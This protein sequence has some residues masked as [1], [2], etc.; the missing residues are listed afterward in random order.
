MVF[1]FTKLSQSSLLECR[2]AQ[3]L[4][5][6]FFETGIPWWDFGSFFVFKI[7]KIKEVFYGIFFRSIR[8]YFYDSTLYI[9][10][11]WWPAYH[12]ICSMLFDKF[13]NM[14]AAP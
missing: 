2:P 9:F 1:G 12:L 7:N 4:P 8:L 6:Q 10:M 14:S 5:Y 3:G 11:A 13:S